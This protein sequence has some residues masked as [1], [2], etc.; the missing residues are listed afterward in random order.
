MTHRIIAVKA[1]NNTV[2]SVTFQNG[3]EKQCDIRK[4]YP[5]FP[6]FKDFE[7]VHGLFQQVKVDIGGYGVS[8]NDNL[9]LDAE[10]LWEDGVE[11]SRHSID[12]PFRLAESLLEARN[13]SGMTQRQLAE[14]TGIHQGDISKIERGLANPSISTLQRLAVGMGM[15]IKIEFVKEE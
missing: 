10:D 1:L 14:I 12:L 8:W 3:V 15:N 11:I 7:T 4:L 5:I 6:Q 2:L 9:D 13:Y